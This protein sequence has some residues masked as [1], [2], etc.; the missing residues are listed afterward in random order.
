M[1]MMRA[2]KNFLRYGEW[3]LFKKAYARVR[4]QGDA[5]RTAALKPKLFCLM[6]YEEI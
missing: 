4:T 3:N 5:P 1:E 6:P 2:L